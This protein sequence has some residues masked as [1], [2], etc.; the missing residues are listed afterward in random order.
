M[1]SLEGSEGRVEPEAWRPQSGEKAEES[2]ED[3]SGECSEPAVPR[4]AG[5]S[6]AGRGGSRRELA[7]QR[8]NGVR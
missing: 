4:R 2:G 1:V 6:Y 5:R 8:Q 3:A 7:S